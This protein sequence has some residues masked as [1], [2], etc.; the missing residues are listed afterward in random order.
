[1]AFENAKSVGELDVANPAPNDLVGQAYLHINMIQDVLL[2]TFKNFDAPCTLD[3]AGMDALVAK[4]QDLHKK[5]AQIRQLMDELVGEVNTFENNIYNVDGPTV[6]AQQSL[7]KGV[8]MWSGTQSS[9]PD[10][11]RIYTEANGSVFG[12]L[13]TG[14]TR[15]PSGAIVKLIPIIKAG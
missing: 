7:P 9:L 11:F 15:K 8:V 5:I 4:I 13:P 14:A 1:M 12:K 6:G 2:A 10:G 3:D